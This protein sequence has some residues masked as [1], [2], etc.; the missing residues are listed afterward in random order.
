L[1]CG[2]MTDLADAIRGHNG[3]YILDL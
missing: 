1:R 3:R 2:G